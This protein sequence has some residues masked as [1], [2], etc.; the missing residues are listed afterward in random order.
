MEAYVEPE[1]Y[2]LQKS[3]PFTMHLSF[4]YNQQVSRT[5][6]DYEF[7]SS[8][9]NFL[10]QDIFVGLIGLWNSLISVWRESVKCSKISIIDLTLIV[11]VAYTQIYSMKQLVP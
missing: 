5:P 7:V 2:N 6:E 4:V 9:V 11:G 1:V 8:S 10:C 3:I